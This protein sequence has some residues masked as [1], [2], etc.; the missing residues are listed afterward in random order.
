[1]GFAVSGSACGGAPLGPPCAACSAGARLAATR[2]TS[3]KHMVN[4]L[5]SITITILKN[6]PYVIEPIILYLIIS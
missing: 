2:R 4:G 6:R 5:I 1:M 3:E